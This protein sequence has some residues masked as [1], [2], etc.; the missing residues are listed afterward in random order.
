MNFELGKLKVF[1]RFF[2]AFKKNIYLCGLKITQIK[3]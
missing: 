1:V 2:F 3:K